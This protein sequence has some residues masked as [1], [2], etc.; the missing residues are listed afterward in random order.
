MPEVS[1]PRATTFC[2]LI[3]AVRQRSVPTRFLMPP[4]LNFSSVQL[5]A[6]Q[7][8]HPFAIGPRLERDVAIVP[9]DLAQARNQILHVRFLVLKLHT[10]G[11]TVAA[12]RKT[13]VANTGNASC[14]FSLARL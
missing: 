14:D 13:S 1:L 9:T 5:F 7:D 11:R 3:L 8:Q 2:L 12:T 4:R 10:R 6:N